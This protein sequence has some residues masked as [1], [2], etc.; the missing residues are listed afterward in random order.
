MRFFIRPGPIKVQLQPLISTGGGVVCRT[1]E[2]SAILLADPNDITAGV[3]GAIHFYISTQYVHDCVAQNQQLDIERYRFSDV[4]PIQ[5]R[6]SS[7]KRGGTGRMGYSLEDD[8]AILNFIANHRKE[9]KGNRIW[10]QME[11]QR[12]TSHSWQSMKDRFLK[13]LQHKLVQKTPEKKKKLSV[14]KESLSSEDNI[15]QSTPQKT[16]KK[17]SKVVSSLDSDTTQ[18]S[19]EQDE[20]TAEQSKRQTPSEESSSLQDPALE[21]RQTDEIRDETREDSD[22]DESEQDCDSEQARNSPKRARMDMDSSAED[23]P[24]VLNDQTRLKETQNSHNPTKLGG[25][26]GKKLSIL[27]KAAREFDDSQTMGGSQEDLPLSQTS[28]NNASDTDEVQIRAARERAIKEQ[29]ANPGPP[30]DSEDPA[31]ANQTHR[32]TSSP[33]DEDAGPSSASLPIT[34]NAHM[35]LFQQDSQEELSQPS[36]S[37]QLSH[38]LLETKQ[39]VI[40]LMQESKKDL[41]EVMKALLK[42]SGDVGLA[43]SYLRDGYNS[44][45][46]GPIWTRYDDEM[47][48]S[49]DS[50][51]SERLLDKYGAEE[52]S[53]R[54][55]FLKADS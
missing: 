42:A 9:A 19:C 29:K 12:I 36:E 17:K 26:S 38:N 50:F 28:S 11:R 32:S 51:E 2:P 34:S 43:L 18:I 35:F 27:R 46:H 14:L 10:Q 21:R 4:Q 24:P 52:V 39:H 3:E 23:T 13:H 5:T 16:P 45:V 6:A 53:K 8:T 48:F 47:L 33:M 55:A 31:Q 54:A 30:T 37:E 1:Q 41:V 25:A 7:R 40:Q 20:G 49:A 44:E 15:S 22:G